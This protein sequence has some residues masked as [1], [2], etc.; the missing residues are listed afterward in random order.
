MRER[1][2]LCGS[3]NHGNFQMTRWRR[4]Y[5]WARGVFWHKRLRWRSQLLSR[6][7]PTGRMRGVAVGSQV[8][9]ICQSARFRPALTGLSF[10]L[11]L[12]HLEPDGFRR[13]TPSSK[14]QL[15]A[16]HSQPTC[17]AHRDCILFIGTVVGRATTELE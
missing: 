13:A 12:R 17:R 14:V 4:L 1:I 7:K 15:R 3:A 8:T 16:G 10:F 5:A 9:G 6:G 2:Q 11:G